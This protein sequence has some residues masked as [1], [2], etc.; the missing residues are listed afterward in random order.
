MN[1]TIKTIGI[2]ILLSVI[3]LAAAC[4]GTGTSTGSDM[5]TIADKK[6]SDKLT[7]TLSNADGKLKK[8]Q[9][10]LML[11]FTDG[12][13]KP[14]DINAA[15]LN[16]QMPAMGSMA[17]MNNSGT[18]TTTSTTGQFK[19]NVDIEMA[20]DWTAKISYDGAETGETTVSTKA[21]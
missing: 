3:G 16:F 19:A 5:K 10:E 8:G 14:V 7:V 12:S 21:E 6:V 13:G 20:G 2:T 4:G 1:R 9:Q 11:S 17:E 18:L 15:T